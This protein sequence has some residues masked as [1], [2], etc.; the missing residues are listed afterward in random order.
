MTYLFIKFFRSD[1]QLHVSLIK[2]TEFLCLLCLNLL[3]SFIE[4]GGILKLHGLCLPY[5]V[6]LEIEVAFGHVLVEFLVGGFHVD[7][8][9]LG[10][11]QVVEFLVFFFNVG[12]SH[13]IDL[14][15]ATSF[16]YSV[17]R[18]WSTAIW[19]CVGRR[20]PAL[21]VAVIYNDI[22]TNVAHDG[23][24]LLLD[25]SLDSSWRLSLEIINN[26]MSLIIWLMITHV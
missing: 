6:F 18:S 26:V 10:N 23:S 3:Y 7:G 12:E 16:V 14:F 4:L 25:A 13:L 17:A 22:W 11:L 20:A 5:D 9:A 24:C 1:V 21:L 19:V 15:K 8:V 2:L